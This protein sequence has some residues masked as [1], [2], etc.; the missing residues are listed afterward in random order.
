[1]TNPICKQPP[2][3]SVIL[4][5]ELQHWFN[6]FVVSSVVNKN[7]IPFPV[8]IAPLYLGQNSFI[9]LLFNDN[10]SKH[11]YEYRYKQE[12]ASCIPRQVFLRIMVYPSAAKYLILDAAGDNVFT[13]QQDDF[14]LLDALLKYRDETS[15]TIID[16][17][18]VAVFDS[19]TSILYAHYDS[20]STN[21]SKM[22]YL[23]LDLKINSNFQRYNNL[24]LISNSTLL[25][26]CFEAYLIEQYY[27]FMSQR[28]PSLI[29]TP[30]YGG[31]GTCLP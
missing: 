4:V 22:I 1:M 10:Y 2:L 26:C 9:E 29:Y 25:D 15:V 21:L 30:P 7:F 23:Y 18:G 28:V 16:T 14:T 20:L 6:Q 17:T 19:T 3:A 5:P 8:D 11:S 24:T 31:E 27:N 13:L 12:S